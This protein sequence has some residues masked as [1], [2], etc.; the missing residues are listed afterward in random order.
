MTDCQSVE[1]K[2]GDSKM[3]RVSKDPEER[4]LELIDTAGRLFMERGYENTS[5][6]DIV[7]EIKV[8]QG[9]FYYHFFS[10]SDILEA[11]VEKNISVM[12]NEIL[13]RAGGKNIRA[14]ERL[15][16]I[17]NFLI[18]YG[19]EGDNVQSY[20]HEESNIVM[21]NKASKMVMARLIPILTGVIADGVAEGTFD[22]K[23]PTETAEILLASLGYILHQADLVAADEKRRK[24]VKSSMEQTLNRVLEVKDFKF[25]LLL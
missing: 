5:V 18:H 14:A 19:M 10:K 9:T 1:I 23:Y 17:I 21:H 4:R 3:V 22:V 20:L 8:A 11:V 15:N 12:M 24:R 2:M 7:K 25:K 16:E 13:N 6:S